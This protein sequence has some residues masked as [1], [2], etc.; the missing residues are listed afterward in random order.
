MAAYLNEVGYVTIQEAITAAVSGDNIEV[1]K[2]SFL[3]T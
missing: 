3:K 1:N 2:G